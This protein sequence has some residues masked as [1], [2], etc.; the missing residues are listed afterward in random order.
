MP[1]YL[2]LGDPLV[3]LADG[4]P[5]LDDGALIIE[6]KTVTALGRREDLEGLG[7]FDRVL[8]SAGHL[9]IPGFING[10]FHA[11]APQAPGMFQFVFERQNTRA[12]RHV[13]DG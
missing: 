11:T 12:S 5:V 3:S 10:H 6:G 1:R 2:V 8:G 7:P 4:A 13:P 9:V